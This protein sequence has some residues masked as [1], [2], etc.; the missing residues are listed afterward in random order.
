MINPTTWIVTGAIGLLGFGAG[1]ALAAGPLS[2]PGAE[3]TRT[4]DSAPVSVG[5]RTSPSAGHTDAVPAVRAVPA[6]RAV[7]AVRAVPAIHA[8]PAMQARHMVP[9]QHAVPAAPARHMVPVQHAMPAPVPVH[10][11]EMER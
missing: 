1:T 10:H 7:P 2:I 5:P 6:I 9:V 4:A 8:V 3:S 11:S